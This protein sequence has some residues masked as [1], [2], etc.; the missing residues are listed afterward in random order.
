MKRQN[1]ILLILGLIVLAFV[2]HLTGIIG[3]RVKDGRITEMPTWHRLALTS[4]IAFGLAFGWLA[5][6]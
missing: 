5:K 6:N 4:C 1:L 2:W 3:F